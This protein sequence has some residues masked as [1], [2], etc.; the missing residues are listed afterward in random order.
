MRRADSHLGVYGTPSPEVLRLGSYVTAL[1]HWQT[2]THDRDAD[3]APKIPLLVYCLG[4]TGEI[5]IGETRHVIAP[6]DIIN[7]P[8]HVWHLLRSDPEIGYHVWWIH[9]DGDHA[10]AL[11]EV[12]GFSVSTPVYNVGIQPGLVAHFERIERLLAEMPIHYSLDAAHEFSSLLIDVRKLVG[13]V[14]F[15]DISRFRALSA[16]A[17]SLEEIARAFGYSKYHFIRVFKKTLG[18][19]PWSYV[20]TLK[21]DRAKSMLH[22]PG[23]SVKEIATALGFDDPNYFSRLFRRLAGTSPVKFRKEL[24]RQEAGEPR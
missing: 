12:A 19:T 1:G 9:Y 22:D 20:L 7:L 13:E 6:G 14:P 4:G 17:R 23:R 18:V 10:K 16:H 24:E 11:A 15:D 5:R 21:I 8:N 3:R 2:R